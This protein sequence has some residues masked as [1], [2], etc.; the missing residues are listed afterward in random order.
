MALVTAQVTKEDAKRGLED[1][2]GGE[3]ENLHPNSNFN[4]PAFKFAKMSNA[5]M[6][7]YVR[8]SD[9][10]SIM[11]DIPHDSIP[12]TVHQRQEVS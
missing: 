11:G 10:G 3:E 2:Y 8:Q 7:V 5:Y 12:P 4:T 9:W 6:L 1:Q